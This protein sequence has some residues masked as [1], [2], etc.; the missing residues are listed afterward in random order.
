[1]LSSFQVPAM[2]ASEPVDCTDSVEIPSLRQLCV[3]YITKHVV[4]NL[5]NSLGALQLEQMHNIQNLRSVHQ[6][7]SLKFCWSTHLTR[8]ADDLEGSLGKE[9]YEALE[10]VHVELDAAKRKIQQVGKVLK[11][12]TSVP[13]PRQEVVAKSNLQRMVA[14]PES[15]SSDPPKRRFAKFGG[16]GEKCHLC[17][18]TVYAAERVATHGS[19]W[20]ATCFRCVTCQHRLGLHSA[21]LDAEL[22]PFCK[23]HFAQAWMRNGDGSARHLGEDCAKPQEEEEEKRQHSGSGKDGVSNDTRHQGTNGRGIVSQRSKGFYDS[24]STSEQSVIPAMPNRRIGVSPHAPSAPSVSAW[25]ASCAEHCVRCSKAVYATERREAR[26]HRNDE[27]R[28]YH[29]KCF[30]CA[31]CNTLLRQNNFELEVETLELLCKAHFVLRGQK[32]AQAEQ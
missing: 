3:E 18:K 4:V 8:S 32:R 19:A 10:R 30:R 31:D 1:M 15:K 24:C 5:D 27:R 25:V 22:R 14:N 28:I 12:P 29:D 13:P 26:T 20:H 2:D 21:E 16:G 6:R 23:A 9:Q 17:S 7:S 11:D